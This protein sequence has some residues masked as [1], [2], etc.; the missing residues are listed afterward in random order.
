MYKINLA[1]Y[2]RIT[3]LSS[4]DIYYVV[5]VLWLIYGIYFIFVPSIILL[6]QYVLKLIYERTN[7]QK[8]HIKPDKI[9]F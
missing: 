2:F 6:S 8:E 7:T 5:I 4:V 9:P 1:Y 3:Q